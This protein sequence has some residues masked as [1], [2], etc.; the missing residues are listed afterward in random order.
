MFTILLT[1]QRTFFQATSYAYI[2]LVFKKDLITR[3]ELLTHRITLLLLPLR[4]IVYIFFEN[5]N[6]RSLL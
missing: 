2:A 3:L 5:E 4:K 1:Q 6:M